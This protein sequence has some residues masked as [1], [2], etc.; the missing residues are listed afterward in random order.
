MKL[1]VDTRVFLWLDAG[2]CRLPREIQE[3][4]IATTNEVYL[5]A[6]SVWEIAIKRASG[7]LNFDGS[8]GQSI[9]THSYLPLAITIEHAERAGALPAFH[10]D[11]FDR[12]LV[13][14]PNWRGWY[15]RR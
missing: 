7:K 4:V 11:P 10:R 6:V 3:A 13:A 8:V 14:R 2:D 5:S 9:L 1:L 15:S 12:L